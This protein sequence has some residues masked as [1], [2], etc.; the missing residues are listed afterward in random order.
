M[1]ISCILLSFICVNVVASISIKYINMVELTNLQIQRASGYND[2]YIGNGLELVIKCFIQTNC[3]DSKSINEM[4][5][6]PELAV[7]CNF[8]HLQGSRLIQTHTLQQKLFQTLGIPMIYPNENNEILRITTLGKKRTYLTGK[9]LHNLR[10]QISDIPSLDDKNQTVTVHD[11]KYKTI[12]KATRRAIIK[13]TKLGKARRLLTKKAIRNVLTQKLAEQITDV[14]KYSVHKICTLI[15]MW[16]SSKTASLPFAIARDYG[17]ID[18]CVVYDKDRNAVK[19]RSFEGIYWQ[20]NVNKM[21]TKIE[22]LNVQL[23]YDSSIPQFEKQ[24]TT[25]TF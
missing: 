19:Y 17:G 20:V 11:D 22:E 18:I 8:D 21:D 9:A 5:T 15:A 24:L 6:V 25:T 7:T 1:K 14:K 4:F 23:L 3:F 16:I 2:D 10:N 13:L 12:Y